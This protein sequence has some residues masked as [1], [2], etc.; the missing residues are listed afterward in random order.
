MHSKTSIPRPGDR[1]ADDGQLLALA[2]FLADDALPHHRSLSLTWLDAD[3]RLLGLLVPI[4][5][6][7]EVPGANVSPGLGRLM[8]GVLERS[9]PGGSVVAVLHRPGDDAI[10][11]SDRAWNAV[12]RAHGRDHAVRVR[13]VFIAAGGAVRPVTLD[14]ALGD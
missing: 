3:D 1:V 13:G 7:P 14:D 4:D 9:A 11:A 5:E 6:L 10:S 8:A 2:T 12:I